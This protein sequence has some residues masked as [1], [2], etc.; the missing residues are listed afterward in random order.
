VPYNEM[1]VPK[2]SPHTKNFPLEAS[3][4]TTRASQASKH[5]L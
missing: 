3:P 1:A 2:H 5:P 4:P